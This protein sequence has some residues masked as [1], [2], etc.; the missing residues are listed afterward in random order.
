MNS[1]KLTPLELA[2]LQAFYDEYHTLGFPLPSA[3]KVSARQNTGA[4]RL[5]KLEAN[6]EV[7][8]PDSYL[9]MGGKFIEMEG[10]PNGLMA[11]VSIANSTLDQLEI[12][13]YGNDSWD[14]EERSWKIV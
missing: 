7:T 4:G 13:V 3:I 2:V 6:A 1:E 11:I 14:G 5:T 8:C 10:I 9:D 12:A